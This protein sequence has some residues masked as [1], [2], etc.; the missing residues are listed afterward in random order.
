[1]LLGNKD[2]MVKPLH[3]LLLEKSIILQPKVLVVNH[4]FIASLLW[5]FEKKYEFF[6]LINVLGF[7]Q[8]YF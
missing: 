6:V 4:K 7:H 1:M 3:C 8:S 5:L 2:A